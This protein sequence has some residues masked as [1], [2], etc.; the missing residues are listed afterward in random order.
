ME[1]AEGYVDFLNKT[2][3][4]PIFKPDSE[5]FEIFEDMT[6]DFDGYWESLYN[7]KY[8]PSVY[9]SKDVYDED[10]IPKIINSDEYY[11]YVDEINKLEF[12]EK[13][14]FFSERTD[15]IDV[16]REMLIQQERYERFSIWDYGEPYIEEIGEM[17]KEKLE[18]NQYF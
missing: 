15:R 12:E 10:K 4:K 6:Y 9:L 17:E 5:E 14:K 11:K 8:E 2:A 3:P 13:V 18:N 7:V 1:E 16:T